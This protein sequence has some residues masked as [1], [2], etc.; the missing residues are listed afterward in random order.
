ML[1][2]FTQSGNALASAISSAVSVD[3]ALYQLSENPEAVALGKICIIRTI[4][5]AEGNSTLAFSR[6]TGRIDES[7]GRDAWVE[8]LFSMAISGL[9]QSEITD[10][11]RNVTFINFH[12]QNLSLLQLKQVGEAK[13]MATVK[14]VNIANRDD[15][16][17]ALN[18]TLNVHIHAIELYDMTAPEL[19][20]QLRLKIMMRVGS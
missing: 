5:K 6:Q 12:A 8:Q 11:F 13:V 16:V 14:N 10:A 15:L 19:L 1:N 20:D 3:D 17:H 7:A 2:R 9:K 4:L 18:R